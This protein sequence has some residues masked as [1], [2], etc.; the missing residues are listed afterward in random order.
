MHVQAGKAKTRTKRSGNRRSGHV[1]QCMPTAEE[2]GTLQTRKRAP[3]SLLQEN[4]GAVRGGLGSKVHVSNRISQK[5]V[6]NRQK[7]GETSKRKLMQT[8]VFNGA[9][10]TC[11]TS[12]KTTQ[13][14][15][16]NTKGKAKH[17]KITSQSTEREKKAN[18]IDENPQKMRNQHR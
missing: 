15:N 4:N 8:I 17:N 9:K 5:F 12:K 1:F 16:S 3:R 6:K 7:K 2:G 18:Q 10:Q 14:S 11:D 13:N